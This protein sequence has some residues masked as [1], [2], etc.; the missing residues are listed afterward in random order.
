MSTVK[1]TIEGAPRSGKSLVLR[2]I[3]PVLANL[4]HTVKACEGDEEI[5]VSFRDPEPHPVRET[6]DVLIV[7]VPK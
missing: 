5:E 6:I 3:A 1:I 2:T 4:G 7:T